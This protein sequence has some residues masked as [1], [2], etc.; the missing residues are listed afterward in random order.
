MNNFTNSSRRDPAGQCRLPPGRDPL[1]LEVAVIGAGFGGIGMGVALRR[2]G[3]RRFI[4]FE[5]ADDLGGVWRDNTYP[6]CNCDVP[7][8]LYSF[9][10]APYRDHRTRYPSQQQI[11]EYLHRV[12]ADAGLEPH[13]RLRTGIQAATYLDEQDRWEL[14]TESGGRILADSIVIAV[15]QLHRPYIPE[16][17]GRADFPG[18]A[19]HTAR[20]DHSQD[21]T[22]RHVAVVGTG[23]SAAQV[24][25]HLAATARQVD[26]FQRT[27]HWVLPKPTL[28]F[29]PITRI[30]LRL[31][32]AHR[33]Y[34]AALH[35]G[36]DLALSPIM[37]RGWSARP[38]E[39]IA[40]H[41]LHRQ[42]SNSALRAKLTPDYPIGA[43]RI[44]LDSD[45][46]PALT[47]PN[48]ELVTSPIQ[49]MTCDGIHT[50]D[51]KHHRA[52]VVV[53][54]TGFRA[55]EFLP[56]LAVR[57]RDGVLLAE[58]WRDGAAAF[59]GLAVAGFPNAYLIAGPN[60]FNPAGSNP[61]MKETQIAYIMAC[62]RWRTE[63][64][65][66]AIE[67]DASTM[68]VYGWRV[69]QALARTVFGTVRWSWYKHP[70]GALTNPWPGSARQF[71][72]LLRH[73]V[74]ESFHKLTPHAYASHRTG[75][76]ARKSS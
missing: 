32:G 48:V 76:P 31:P 10:F 65:A 61:E 47:K 14:I 45:F 69:Q 2:A 73:P 34:R 53:W 17:P 43:K 40:R 44:I 46:Y 26:V 6:G 20:W 62:L 75:L 13:V 67:V 11:L 15:G 8:H 68:Q 70:S 59:A 36:A 27:P 9:S 41:H 55:T 24:L 66:A 16:I 18:P 33:V 29:G 22:G 64:G 4:I 58:Q 7:A 21:I 3:I 30:A 71:D 35:H 54:A 63:T 74:S 72:R 49:T 57:G 60:S 50:M 51:G 37:R 38:A 56:G 42:I 12:T 39:C 25:P 23:S 28:H 52:D 5:K 1:D 19:F